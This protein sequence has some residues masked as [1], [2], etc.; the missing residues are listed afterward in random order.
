MGKRGFFFSTILVLFFNASAG[1]WTPTQFQDWLRADLAGPSAV[2]ENTKRKAAGFHYI[3]VAGFLNEGIVGYF[4][5]NIKE[6][7]RLGVPARSI[8]IVSPCSG[9]T[10]EENS[11]IIRE[12][13]IDVLK[14]ESDR[15]V[16]FAHSRGAV[17]ALAFALEHSD[18]V[19]DR[20]EAM[21]LVQGAFG[22]SGIADYI[23]GEGVELDSRMP[24]PFRTF[25]YLTGKTETLL[26]PHIERGLTSLTHSKAKA[27]WKDLFDKRKDSIP[28]VTSKVFYV[29]GSEH[30][31]KVTP[32]L[33]ANAWY[34]Q[35]YYGPNDGM[36]TIS[37]QTLAGVGTPLAVITADH[38]DLT[39]IAPISNAP[40]SYRKGIIRTV[41]RA[42]GQD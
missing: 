38:A 32:L 28:A 27:F 25:F 24:Q 23:R 22:G 13:I 1:A 3:F 18:F 26:D 11:A 39:N 29:L 34:L 19:R 10:F 16:L 41:F 21:F 4:S 8:S 5:E 6:L 31:K 36:V 40:E 12:G 35:T 2:P 20:V 42:V 17:D 30:P 14:R 33:Q 7:K 9:K 37:D 15:A